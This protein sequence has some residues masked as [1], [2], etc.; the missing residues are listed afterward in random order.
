M[1]LNQVKHGGAG[2]RKRIRVG[3]GVAGRRGNS[4]GRGMR[5]YSS[6]AGSTRLLGYEGGQ[7][8]FH[9][10]LPKRGFSNDLFAK[11]YAIVNVGDLNRFSS[12]DTVDVAA[13]REKRLVR[14]VYDGVKIL[15]RG[16]LEIAL[17]VEA[18][19]FSASAQQ[20]IRDAGGE[21]KVIR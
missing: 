6:R 17:K 15:G 1:K 21:V 13:L 3:R 4:C 8:P 10:R 19:G 2:V 5:G 7:T 11:R 12:G 14:K 18:H 20:K 16:A 9:E